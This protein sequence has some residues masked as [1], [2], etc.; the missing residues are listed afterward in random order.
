MS[1]VELGRLSWSLRERF[2]DCSVL[3]C[4]IIDCLPWNENVQE[5]S[6][7]KALINGCQLVPKKENPN[8][9]SRSNL[10]RLIDMQGFVSPSGWK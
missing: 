9:I 2:L 10:S 3:F 4:F 1:G 7:W 5:V 6:A 8:G